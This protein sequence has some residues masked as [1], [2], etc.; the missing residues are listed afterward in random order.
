MTGKTLI[1]ANP[2][3][4][5]GRGMRYAERVRDLL[6][7]NHADVEIRPTSARGEAEAFAAEAV[8][9]GYAC[10]AACGGDGT[11]HEVVNGLAGTDVA[12]GILP[13]GRGNDFAR[14]MEIPSPPEKAASV[15]QQGYVRPFDLGKVN[16]RYFA[17]VVTLGFD[18]EVARLVYE[19][20][21]PFKGTA[22]YLWG[23]ARMLRVYRGV[24][25]RMTGDF[26]TIDQTVLL[27]AT[28]NTSTY[29]GGIRI[30][31]NASPVDGALDICL[32]RMMSAG[33]ILRV[34]PRVYLGGHLTHPDIFSY[35]TGRLSME[36]ERPVVLFADGEPAG[37]TPA[38]II[39]VP[40]ALRV[41]CPVPSV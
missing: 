12:L 35:R 20:Q 22:A 32:V 38:E 14:A 36:T 11:V 6:A 13:C 4:G 23:L 24:A 5:S 33:R 16:D 2:T 8:Q 37:E 26:G 28:G 15:L 27:A 1:V 9:E 19:G 31:P 30:V 34:F 18:S 40:G 7:A 3:S 10:V 39:A 41:A 17:T 29:G 25:L 21:V